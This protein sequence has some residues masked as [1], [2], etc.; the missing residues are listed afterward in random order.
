M[1]AADVDSFMKEYAAYNG[2]N[3]ESA[4]IK[5]SVSYLLLDG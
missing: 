2:N 3:D 1:P 4:V 5:V